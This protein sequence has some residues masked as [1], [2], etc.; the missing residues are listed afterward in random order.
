MAQTLKCCIL[1]CF[2]IAQPLLAGEIP[3][4]GIFDGRW[5]EN[6]IAFR[7]ALK[8]INDDPNLLFGHTLKPIIYTIFPDQPPATNIA[9][10]CRA[11]ESGAAAL[12]GPETST[13]A[14]ASQ[15]LLASR[16]LPQVA[17]STTSPALS[18]EG[19]YSFFS[20]IIPPDNLQT[21][22]MVD[23]II[24]YGWQRLAI[25]TGDDD[26]GVT[27]MQGL[28]DSA[29]AKTWEVLTVQ[30]VPANLNIN[31]GRDVL[32]QLKVVQ[33]SLARIIVLHVFP[34]A[35]AAI[36]RDAE[37]LGMIGS[38]FVF[39]ASDGS[40]YRPQ[41]VMNLADPA[42]ANRSDG[43]IGLRFNSP[44]NALSR[45]FLARWDTLDNATY[46]N[47][48][49]SDVVNVYVKLAYD[50][51]LV[52]GQGMHQL[53]QATVDQIAAYA[54][55][56]AN[57]TTSCYDITF[58]FGNQLQ[59]A[60]RAHTVTNALTG[61]VE[62]QPDGEPIGSTYQILNFQGTEVVQIGTA[63][64]GA[65][66]LDI[67]EP[68][69]WPGGMVTVP[70][71]RPLR[72]GTLRMGMITEFPWTF[73]NSDEQWT[74]FVVSLAQRLGEDIGFD[75]EFYAVEDGQY[76][77]LDENRWTGVVGDL[78]RDVADISGAPLTITS[79]RSAVIT[80]SLPY[81]DTGYGMAVRAG[82]TTEESFATYVDVFT[83][84]LWYLIFGSIFVL[85]IGV[86]MFENFYYHGERKEQLRD[87]TVQKELERARRKHDQRVKKL[88]RTHSLNASMADNIRNWL[89]GEDVKTANQFSSTNMVYF[90]LL[91]FVGDI[92]DSMPRSFPGRAITAV[93][94][95]TYMV[96]VHIY[97]ASLSAKLTAAV[98][99]ELAVST[100]ADLNDA[101][102]TMG[103]LRNS[104]PESY[105]LSEVDVSNVQGRLNLYN[106]VPEAMEALAT[107]EI[108]AFIFDDLIVETG[109]VEHATCAIVKLPLVWQRFTWGFGI[110]VNV[111]NA[112]A[113]AIDT[114]LVDYQTNGFLEQL[115]GDWLPA[116]P[117][118]NQV[119]VES[120]AFEPVHL[121]SLVVL[122]YAL[123][124][125]IG[126]G[127]AMFG[128]EYLALHGSR[129]VAEKRS[130]KRLLD[131]RKAS[132]LDVMPLND[133][134][135]LVVDVQDLTQDSGT[136]SAQSSAK[137]R[138]PADDQFDADKA[139]LAAADLDDTMEEDTMA[140]KSDRGR[141]SEV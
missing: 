113:E 97:M 47:I 14:I 34:D 72:Y 1:L 118:C 127:F 134:D 17:F 54:E 11:L 60:I 125:I 63:R 13:G 96:L 115:Q 39:L 12:V 86:G 10:G 79:A 123:A 87:E 98:P 52:V 61:V 100:V 62:L 46:P 16:Q 75:L 141:L 6:Q 38:G 85:A 53:G 21:Q 67:T 56:Q 29:F 99:V 78:L 93:F 81:I 70:S 91:L 73:E 110:G 122:F 64:A 82:A 103:T 50:V 132:E 131:S 76:G 129:Y 112:L 116:L 3:I 36:F 27:G 59:A 26:Y 33:D 28:I 9:F 101:R 88:S 5:P 41:T 32:T 23:L 40:M 102:I 137:S 20:R 89:M 128:I 90:S 35:A 92:G 138:T 106:S 69:N 51:G 130:S 136:L 84:E 95:I 139:Q 7:L 37:V 109:V 140:G 105:L 71:D 24:K 31:D 117:E 66:V 94:A 135:G 68:V 4:A 108:D 45:A 58:P 119:Q 121:D 126:I 15:L 80:Y 111:P 114:K 25:V 49:S 22:V 120:N 30:R 77:A 48:P 18:N 74:G 124:V 42:G 55:M 2:A 8:D 57:S 19:L 83:D 43:L 107:E 133:T 44:D 104:A 65:G